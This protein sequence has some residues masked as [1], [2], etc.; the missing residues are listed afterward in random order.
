MDDIRKFEE[1]YQQLFALEEEK[2]IA[3]LKILEKKEPDFYNE[4]VKLFKNEP[5]ASAYFDSMEAKISGIMDD[6]IHTTGNIVGN[7]RLNELL[8]SGGMANVY[9]ASR[10]D[11]SF[12]RDSALK[13]IKRGI[14]TDEIISRFAYERSILASLKHDNITQ[15]YDGG[16]TDKGLPYFVMEFIDGEDIITY[17]NRHHLSIREKLKLFLQVCDAIDFAHK[18]LIIHRDIK[19]GNILVEKDGKVKLMDFGIAKIFGSEEDRFFTRADTRILTL[20]YASPEQISGDYVNTTSDIYQAG[21]LLYELLTNHKTYDKKEKNHIFEFK[22]KSVPS[23]LKSIIQIATRENPGERYSSAESLKNDIQNYLHNRPVKAKGD[24]FAY[25]ARKFLVRNKV[26]LISVFMVLMLIGFITG[27]YIIDITEARKA[28]AYRT[29]HANS[30]MNFLLSTFANQLPRNASGDTLTVFDLMN[31][32]EYQLENDKTFFKENLSRVYNLLADIH[33]RYKNAEKSREFYHNAITYHVDDPFDLHFSH[34]QKYIAYVGL[35]RHFFTENLRDSSNYYYEKAI[36]LAEE[37]GLNPIEAYTGLGKL[38]ILGGNYQRTDSLFKKGMKYARMPDVSSKESLAFFLGVYGN[39]LARYFPLENKEK[40]DSLFRA[41][42]QLFNERIQ[43]NSNMDFEKKN[44]FAGFYKREDAIKGP[45]LKIQHPTSY[46]EIINYYGIYFYRIQ[47][48]DSALYYFNEAYKANSKYYGENSIVA[49][50]NA[51]NIAVIN[52]EKGNTEKARKIFLECWNISRKNKDIQPAFSINFF[53]NYASVL[54]TEEK[55]EESLQ[56]FDTV[57]MLRKKYAPE[58]DFGMN[59]AYRHI[60]Q[61]LHKLGKP[62]KALGYLQKVVSLHQEKAGDKGFQD[63]NAQLQ[64]IVIHGELG[65][66]E[67]MNELYADNRSKIKRRFG[68]DSYYIHRNMLAKANAMLKMNRTT[69]T[70]K[71]LEPVLTDS[72]NS[73]DK[74]HLLFIYAKSQHESG[75]TNRA[76]SIM[77]QLYAKNDLEPK[78]KE[79]LEDFQN[80]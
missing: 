3:W 47:E 74:N 58:N 76:D 72:I 80:R 18:N 78:V 48:Y 31:R 54:Y 75:N 36:K 41:S 68:D 28:A 66:F 57:L 14:D 69:E 59:H 10:I 61:N 22:R 7:Y 71:F 73:R 37:K 51:S 34:R 11:G 45:V 65:N 12:Q 43:Y 2:R 60:G 33:F 35:G 4:F 44:V 53:H 46:A 67:Q 13:I 23:E 27:K 77:N 70:V 50:E 40:I 63:V 9:K 8:G 49:L 62:Y 30:T 55:Y 29:M 19:P 17:S 42:L 1:Y 39:F 25:H 38:E 52:R 16:V 21:V 32:M 64:M 79:A 15:L 5:E 6:K 20:E 26:A 24:T 56:A